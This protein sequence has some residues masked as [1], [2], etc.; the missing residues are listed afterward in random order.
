MPEAVN[1]EELHTLHIN[2]RAVMQRLS[3][4]RDQDPEKD[5]SPTP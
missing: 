5:R 3:K 1:K 4:I 2:V